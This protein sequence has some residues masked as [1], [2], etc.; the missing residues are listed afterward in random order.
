MEDLNVYTRL[1]AHSYSFVQSGVPQKKH[2]PIPDEITEANLGR[3]LDCICPL[4]HGLD[5]LSFGITKSPDYTVTTWGRV[6]CPQ[7][8]QLGMQVGAQTHE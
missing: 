3:V 8:N 5:Y 6:R 2:L 7:C 1:T 4:C